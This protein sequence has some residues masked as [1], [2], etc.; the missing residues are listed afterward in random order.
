MI[1]LIIRLTPVTLEEIAS[2]VQNLNPIGISLVV[3]TTFT[4]LWLTAYKWKLITQKLTSNN[5]TPRKFY[6]FYVVFANLIAQ[7]V[8]QQIGLT[9][10]QSL[11]LKVHKVSTLSQGFFSVIYDQFLNI[12][13]PVLLLP[14]SVFLILGKISL[15]IAIFVSLGILLITHCIIL[16]WHKPLVIFLFRAYFKIKKIA[17]RNKQDTQ[18]NLEDIPILSTRFTIRLFWL[19]VFRHGNWILR[20][21]CV[22]IAGGFTINFWSIAFT[23]NL[24]QT[25]M[26]VSIT[27][28]NLGFMEWSWIGGLELLGVP[29]SVAGNFA[30]IQRI[31]GIVA[32]IAIAMGC[33]L[34]LAADRFSLVKKTLKTNEI[35]KETWR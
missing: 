32:L 5:Q 30:F 24:V 27:P 9:F 8:P 13:I 16:Q 19:S 25:A 33:G 20:S 23:T 3:I 21:F 7:F 18:L 31:L 26:I 17:S 22:V 2:T 10:V 11:A 29:A 34:S 35:S 12:L 28:A 6:L 14:P 4:H 15:P 1:W